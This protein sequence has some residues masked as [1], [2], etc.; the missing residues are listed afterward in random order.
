MERGV[1]WVPMVPSTVEPTKVRIRRSNGDDHAASE[2][3]HNQRGD[4]NFLVILPPR[5]TRYVSVAERML[6][7]TTSSSSGPTGSGL[8]KPGSVSCPSEE[9]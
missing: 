8:G 7:G 3:K 6:N 4:G 5:K 1:E 9:E 2:R